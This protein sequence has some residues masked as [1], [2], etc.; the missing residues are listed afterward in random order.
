MLMLGRRQQKL[1]HE[2]EHLRQALKTK[3]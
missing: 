2:L 3:K 1:A